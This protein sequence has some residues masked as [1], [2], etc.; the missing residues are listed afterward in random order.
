MGWEEW[1]VLIAV[2]IF[3]MKF[4]FEEIR[5]RL[6]GRMKNAE[7]K[8]PEDKTTH[9]PANEVPQSIAGNSIHTMHERINRAPVQASGK[10]DVVQHQHAPIHITNIEIHDSVINRS[11]ISST[12]ESDDVDDSSITVEDAVIRKSTVAGKSK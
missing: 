6:F 11:T 5:K 2:F 12:V 9:S 8:S 4:G 1:F 7:E 3:A 10:D